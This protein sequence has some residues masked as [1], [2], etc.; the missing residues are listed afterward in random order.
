MSERW[1]LATARFLVRAQNADQ[2]DSAI[3]YACNGDPLPVYM[4]ILDHE[5]VDVNE[6]HPAP[7]GRA[8][9]TETP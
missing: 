5:V 8:A 9:T 1:F 7:A 6:V 2:V 3:E 4:T